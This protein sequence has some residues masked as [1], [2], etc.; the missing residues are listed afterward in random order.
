[1]FTFLGDKCYRVASRTLPE[2]FTWTIALNMCKGYGADLVSIQ[3]QEEQG[4][5]MQLFDTR[6][7]VKYF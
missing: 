5:C 1:M 2:R 4:N 6:R 7:F 3:S